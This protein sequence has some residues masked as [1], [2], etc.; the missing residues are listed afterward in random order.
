[1]LTMKAMNHCEHC[2]SQLPI[3]GPL[4]G[5]CPRCLVVTAFDERT[6]LRPGDRLGPYEILCDPR[7]GGMGEVYKAKDTRLGRPVAIKVLAP[8]I[9]DDPESKQRFERESR[10]LATL[11]HP[12][13]C[14]V[15][16]IGQ[17]DGVDF[18]VM[19]YL[20][21]ETLAARVSQG[22]LTTNDALRIAI[23]IGSG[24]EAAHR[25]GII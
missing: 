6:H 11:S 22:S 4:R 19:E 9:A 15:F 12:N 17:E 1:F 5:Q 2:G 8:E 14:P 7:V 13:I 3:D 16:D 18:L 24:L 20:D 23:Q 10:I 21:G 25:A